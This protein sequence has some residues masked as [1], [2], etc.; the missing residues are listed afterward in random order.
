MQKK[1]SSSRRPNPPQPKRQKIS[2][3]VSNSH[4]GKRTKSL[5]EQTVREIERILMSMIQKKQGVFEIMPRMDTEYSAHVEK[6]YPQAQRG[7]DAKVLMRIL[8][9]LEQRGELVR[10]MLSSMTP[11]GNM[12]YKSILIL[13]EIDPATNPIVRELRDDLQREAASYVP[14]PVIGVLPQKSFVLDLASATTE[15]GQDL[16]APMT[17]VHIPTPVRPKTVG[18]TQAKTQSLSKS[19][20]AHLNLDPSNSDLDGASHTETKTVSEGL[21]SLEHSES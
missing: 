9:M 2:Q 11:I 18:R 5:D 17:A 12:Q 1:R 8:D 13:P 10:I 4:L 20:T 16:Q 14:A 15:L 19:N 21:S 6:Y 7:V 3:A